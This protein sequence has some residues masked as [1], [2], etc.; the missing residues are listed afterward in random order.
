MESTHVPDFSAESVIYLREL[1][2]IIEKQEAKAT[3]YDIQL[4][5]IGIEPDDEGW[6]QSRTGP[7]RRLT[8]I[9]EYPSIEPAGKGESSDWER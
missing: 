1:A 5:T 4:E 2:D 9:W 6:P 3:Y 7:R 8:M